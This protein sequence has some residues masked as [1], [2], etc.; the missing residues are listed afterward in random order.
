MFEVGAYIVGLAVLYYFNDRESKKPLDEHTK[1]AEKI[2]ESAD[3]AIPSDKV[4]LQL[5]Q[6]LNAA[7]T[8]R[9][10]RNIEILIMLIIVGL[11]VHAFGEA[12]W[13]R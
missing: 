2:F 4:L 3:G 9:A 11:L 7:R 12:Y 8:Q 6:N 13:Q 1:L 10:L 5:Q